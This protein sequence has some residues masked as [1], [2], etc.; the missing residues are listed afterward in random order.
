MRRLLGLAALGAALSPLGAGAVQLDGLD[1][2]RTWRLRALDF[3][4]N[5]AL[6]TGVLRKAL[7]TRARP[8]FTVWRSRPIFDPILFR[9]DLDR[10]RQLYRS[11]GYYHA[12]VEHDLE[13]PAEGDALRAVVYVDEGPPVRVEH[14]EVSVAD[15]PPPLPGAPPLE[16][17][18]PLS[19]GDVFT[20]D[21]YDAGLA[22]LRTWFRDRAYARVAIVKHARVDVD[23]NLATV[24]YRIDPGPPSVFGHLAVE[25]ATRVDPDVVLRELPFATGDRFEQRLLDRARANL[26]GLNLFR[27][28]RLD[29][30]DSRK[31]DVDV[32]VRVVEAKPREV[33]VGIGY[34]TEEQVR[35]IAS[36]RD[37][38][39]FGD[40]R[41]LGF[42]GRISTLRRTLVAD[43]LQPH[44]PG[45]WNR[46]RLLFLQEIEDE[47]PFTLERTRIGP[48]LE[49][50]QD[51]HVTAFAFHRFEYDHLSDVEDAV[52]RRLPDAT[53]RTGLLS[54]FGLGIEWNTTN[55][56]L[57]PSRGWV[58]AL[59]VEPVGLG[60][61]FSFVRTVL[62]GRVYQPLVGDLGGAMR[63]RLG[64]SEPFG[65]TKDVP[66]FERFYA[67]GLNSVRGYGRWRVGP[68]ADDHPLGGKSLVEASV[69]LR[70]PITETIGAAVFVDAGQVALP[71]FDFPFDDLDYGAGFGVRYRSPVG[72]L[73]LDLAFPSDPPGDDQH[74]QVHVSVGATF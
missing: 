13:M 26:V 62:E 58:T 31:P 6:R 8:W 12:R 53:P 70:H 16:E 15:V 24:R 67:G 47:D 9:D 34:D 18:V 22:V 19:P 32:T 52:R 30:D 42:S 38:D 17:L 5:H 68:L 1:L 11:H 55:D 57:D 45:R 50:L 37:Y 43:F 35:G 44:F 41:Q 27:S 3:R 73:R 20:Q 69:E 56:A 33:R 10:L 74:W 64:S 36:W 60:G 25:G 23:R 39:F 66:V 40:A 48:R 28:I 51:D 72:P 49:F 65:D 59:T 54:G 4:G 2:A 29:E 21:G 46:T 61:D 63:V 71:S 14:V 7:V